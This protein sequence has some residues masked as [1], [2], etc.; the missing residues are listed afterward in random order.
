MCLNA[1]TYN[2]EGSFVHT[3]ATVIE[4][5]LDEKLANQEYN[6]NKF[7]GEIQES[8]S[9]FVI[10]IILFLVVFLCILFKQKRR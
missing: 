4:K 1:K 10:I 7:S 5:L 9:P 3:D 8:S 2:Q 6:N